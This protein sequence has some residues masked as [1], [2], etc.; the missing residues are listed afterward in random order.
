[1]IFLRYLRL[2]IYVTLYAAAELPTYD[3][4]PITLPITLPHVT[5]AMLP[6]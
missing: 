2:L 6:C 1:M 4:S 3:A 5:Y